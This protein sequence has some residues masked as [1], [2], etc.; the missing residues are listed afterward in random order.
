MQALPFHRDP[1]QRQ[2]LAQDPPQDATS[3]LASTSYR[4]K[5][6]LDLDPDS[7]SDLPNLLLV[8]SLVE[9]ALGEDPNERRLGYALFVTK[10]DSGHLNGLP[11][12]L[13]GSVL[14]ADDPRR[15][16]MMARLGWKLAESLEL[17]N[18]D[19]PQPNPEYVLVALPDG[20]DMIERAR[21]DKKRATGDTYIVGHP[22]GGRY[23]RAAQFLPHLV[24]L[25]KAKIG[26]VSESEIEEC[27]C[28]VCRVEGNDAQ[29]NMAR[30]KDSKR[31][32]GPW[33]GFWA[34]R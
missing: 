13:D 20:Y 21:V 2:A 8:E 16:W 17:M 31:I 6:V 14:A 1:G 28:R 34:L 24:W 3:A 5:S 33:G 26:G 32:D 22:S 12:A 30:I 11:W 10:S 29:E 4:W 19:P 15:K 7:A 25:V 23:D 18:P 27:E 9:F